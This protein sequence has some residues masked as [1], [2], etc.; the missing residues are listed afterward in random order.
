MNGLHEETCKMVWCVVTSLS[1]LKK[2]RWALKVNI[3]IDQFESG[4]F[5]LV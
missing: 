1:L 5:P 4:C 3:E 2:L